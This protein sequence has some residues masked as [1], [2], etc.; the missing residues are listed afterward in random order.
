MPETL[1]CGEIAKGPRKGSAYADDR[2]QI[3]VR[4]FT[5][6][7]HL[8]DIVILDGGSQDVATRIEGNR[9]NQATVEG[10]AFEVARKIRR[11]FCFFGSKIE[12]G[13]EDCG[14]VETLGQGSGN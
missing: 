3:V 9:G 2:P 1:N 11:V 13:C 14:S 4:R 8:G 6:Q 7:G 5:R 10:N 12:M